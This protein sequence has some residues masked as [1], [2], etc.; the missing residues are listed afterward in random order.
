MDAVAW[1]EPSGPR[2]VCPSCGAGLVEYRMASRATR[3]ACGTTKKACAAGF[4]FASG[5]DPART[6]A[7]YRRYLY[8]RG[9]TDD[10][11]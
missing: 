10:D 7:L 11:L 2:V 5:P 3:F 9:E 6:V 4:C 1:T 8:E